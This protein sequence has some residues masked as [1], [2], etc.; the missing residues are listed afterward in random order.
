VTAAVRRRPGRAKIRI[1]QIVA[2]SY[3]EAFEACVRGM[4]GGEYAAIHRGDCPARGEGRCDCN[5]ILIG[6]SLQGS[7]Q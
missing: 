3:V 6:P 2:D 1:Q 5:F 4:A 7:W